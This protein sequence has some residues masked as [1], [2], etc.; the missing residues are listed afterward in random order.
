MVFS[1]VH[2]A[3]AGREAYVDWNAAIWEVISPN[4]QV[5]SE[6][7]IVAPAMARVYDSTRLLL[8]CVVRYPTQLLPP[9]CVP[10]PKPQTH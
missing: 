3:D 6:L 1:A 4:P 5:A 2:G 10:R 9:L 8:Y 7:S